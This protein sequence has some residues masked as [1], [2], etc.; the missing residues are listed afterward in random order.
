MDHSLHAIPVSERSMNVYIV[1]T[2]FC[3]SSIRPFR[4]HVGYKDIIPVVGSVILSLSP[5]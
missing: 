3:D 1:S 2:C 5:C 4:Q